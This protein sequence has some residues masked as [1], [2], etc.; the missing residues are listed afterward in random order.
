MFLRYA[1][2]DAAKVWKKDG[3]VIVPSVMKWLFEDPEVKELMHHEVHIYY[4]HRTMMKG[5]K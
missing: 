5:R 2:A 1:G 3:T 4:H